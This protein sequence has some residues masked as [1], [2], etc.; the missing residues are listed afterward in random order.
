MYLNSCPRGENSP[1][2]VTLAAALRSE[3][4]RQ[5]KLLLFIRRDI[6]VIST[7]LRFAAPT[8]SIVFLCLQPLVST[9]TGY[10]RASPVLSSFST[11]WTLGFWGKTSKH[12]RL[13]GKT[14]LCSFWARRFAS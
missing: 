12:L 10:D 9:Q 13:R 8:Q 3:P 5:P 7:T 2:L 11:V 6:R 1:N 4:R 14:S